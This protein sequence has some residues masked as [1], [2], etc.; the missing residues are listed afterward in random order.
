VRLGGE[1]HVSFAEV[2]VGALEAVVLVQIANAE[3]ADAAGPR[4]EVRN[5]SGVK[6]AK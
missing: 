3:V 2:V 1:E 4:I 5:H 6:V